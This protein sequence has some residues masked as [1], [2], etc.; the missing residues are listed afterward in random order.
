MPSWIDP[1]RRRLLAFR[2]PV[3]A[4][5][6]IA[7]DGSG[8]YTTINEALKDI[9]L[10]SETPFVLYIKA[11]VYNEI[12]TFTENMTNLVVIGDG[13]TRTVITGDLNFVDGIQTYATATVS[14][15]GNNFMAKYIGFANTAGPTK[16]QAVAL[17]VQSDF[18]IFYQCNM[19]GLGGG[20]GSLVL[21]LG[22]RSEYGI[23]FLPVGL[24]DSPNDR[25]LSEFHLRNSE[26]AW[27]K[28]ST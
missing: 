15:L 10:N 23:G 7:K 3:K 9:P 25:P 13:P 22:T 28:K 1:V 19:D 16:H 24:W 6:V 11:G 8:K 27:N 21:A 20:G 17:L 2:R 18:S 4:D 5:L 14:V 26:V 12:V